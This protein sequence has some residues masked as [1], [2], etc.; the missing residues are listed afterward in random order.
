MNNT[1]ENDFLDFPGQ[2]GYSVQVRWANVH[3]VDVKF[4]QHLTYQKSKNLS[5][6]GRII[7][8]MKRCTFWRHGVYRV[9]QSADLLSA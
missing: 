1:I 3:A 7:P 2:S 5:I 6:F 9:Q 4:S 8:K